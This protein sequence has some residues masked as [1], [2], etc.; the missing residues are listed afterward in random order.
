LENGFAVDP[1]DIDSE[2]GIEPPGSDGML[3]E[4][5]PAGL[6][7]GGGVVNCRL[8]WCGKAAAREYS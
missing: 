1:A 3:I 2:F 8:D 4:G 5:F 6:I 7:F